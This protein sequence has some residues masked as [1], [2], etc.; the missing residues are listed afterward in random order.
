MVI[1]VEISKAKRQL[2]KL[3]EAAKQGEDVILEEGGVP[4]VRLEPI[5]AATATARPSSN[6]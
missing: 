6:K 3:M 2:S 1:R 5:F 4:L